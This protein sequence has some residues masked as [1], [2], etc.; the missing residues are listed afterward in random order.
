MKNKTHSHSAN[1]PVAG[2][3]GGASTSVATEQVNQN[4]MSS[5]IN[6]AEQDQFI[7]ITPVCEY[8]K[9]GYDHHRK[10]I[11]NDPILQSIQRKNADYLTFGDNRKRILLSKVGFIRWIQLINPNTIDP[12]LRVKFIQ[13]QTQVFE[14]LYA[15]A[16]RYN[17]E[18]TEEATLYAEI[19]HKKS[20]KVRLYREIRAAEAQLKTLYKK[21]YGSVQLAL[22]LS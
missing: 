5:L 10:L 22:M 1:L 16:D 11:K 15:A 21:K 19:Q 9:I 14:F 6:Y 20:E 2:V 8:F 13:F 18:L 4:D 12:Q 17:Q 3:S 7:W